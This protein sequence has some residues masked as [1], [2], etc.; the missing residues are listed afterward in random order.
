MELD[1]GDIHILSAD[2]G[3]SVE[4]VP[5]VCIDIWSNG[6]SMD[7]W[8]WKSFKIQCNDPDCLHDNSV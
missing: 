7:Y 8:R 4:P 3:L 1:S 2:Y 5:V 6:A